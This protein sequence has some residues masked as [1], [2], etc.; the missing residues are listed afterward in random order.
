MQNLVGPRSHRH[1]AVVGDQGGGAALERGDRVGTHVGG[2]G[3]GVIGAPDVPAAIHRELVDAR[4][5]R[6]VGDGEHGRPHR[7]T[8]NDAADVIERGKAGQVQLH[9]RGRRPAVGRLQHRA[10]RIDQHEVVELHVAVVDGRR[11]DDDVAVGAA[12]R[13]VACGALHQAAAQHV[14]GRV[15]HR[16]LRVLDEFHGPSTSGLTR[17]AGASP[18]SSASRSS[19]TICACR[20]SVFQVAPPMCGVSTTFAIPTS[21][22]S[23]GSHSPAK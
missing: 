13:D 1:Q 9:L 6:L 4:R 15:Q 22:W 16:G 3:R 21:G 5:D 10:A 11:G 20:A 23:A 19:A 8:V 7:M 14:L 12:R 2:P 17:W 18:F